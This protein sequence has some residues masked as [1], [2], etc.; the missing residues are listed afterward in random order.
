MY[1]AQDAALKSAVPCSNPG[2]G[3][4]ICP[5]KAGGTRVEVP[6]RWSELQA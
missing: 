5:S 4:A 6:Y 1:E 3:F 2:E